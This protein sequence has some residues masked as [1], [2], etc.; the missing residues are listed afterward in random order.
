MCRLT[1]RNPGHGGLT[2][3]LAWMDTAPDISIKP[4]W[5]DG[6]VE[7]NIENLLFTMSNHNWLGI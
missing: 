6:I 5:T 1:G 7:K 2:V 4:D 3:H